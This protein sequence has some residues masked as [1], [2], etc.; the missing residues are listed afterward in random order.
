MPRTLIIF[1]HV[2]QHVFFFRMEEYNK[3]IC[4]Y[5]KK[6]ISEAYINM[7]S[8]KTIILRSFPQLLVR[9]QLSVDKD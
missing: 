1:Y 9:W 2:P 7:I 5:K 3:D 4:F 8:R 6:I